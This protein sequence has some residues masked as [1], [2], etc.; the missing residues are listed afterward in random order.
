MSDD[1]K[2]T[3][4]IKAQMSRYAARLTEGLS[5]VKRRFVGEML[6]GMQAAKDV[7]VSEVARCLNEPIKLIKTENRPCRNLADEDLTDTINRWTAWEGGG[8][9]DD[10]RVLVIDL[11]TPL[12]ALPCPPH[13]T[14]RRPSGTHKGEPKSGRAR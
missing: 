10:E 12:P 5:K 14:Y 13:A 11:G 6:Y 3:G 1:S 9:V 8:A 4:K 2:L 7:K